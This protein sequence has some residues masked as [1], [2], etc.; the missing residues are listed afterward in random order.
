MWD[1]SSQ[2]LYDCIRDTLYSF[3]TNKYKERNSGNGLVYESYS[4]YYADAVSFYFDLASNSDT[5]Y[6]KWYGEYMSTDGR[7]H[8][9]PGGNGATL[10]NRYDPKTGRYDYTYNDDGRESEYDNTYLSFY[11]RL[12]KFKSHHSDYDR[13]AHASY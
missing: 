8:T 10:T 13:Q 11:D 5:T 9:E 6:D 3:S 1:A 2:L 12:V 4:T 7:L